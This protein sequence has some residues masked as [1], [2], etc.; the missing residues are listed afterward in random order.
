MTLVELLPFAAIAAAFWLLIVRPSSVRR[1]AQAALVASLEP[2]L[3]IMTTA[4]VFGTVASV[5]VELVSVEIAPGV[6]IEM[7][8]AAIA[9]V[10]PSEGPTEVPSETLE[11][12]SAAPATDAVLTVDDSHATPALTP[13]ADR[14]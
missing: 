4:G 6:V 5:D 9:R 2:G 13:E 12:G 14:G 3:R 10:L 7:L 1:K 8:P 11:A